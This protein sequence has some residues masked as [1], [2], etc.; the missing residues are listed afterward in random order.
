MEEKTDRGLKHVAHEHLL[1]LNENYIAKEGEIKSN[2]K[3]EEDETYSHLVHL[4]AADELSLD[5][6]LE[7]F[8]KDK[9]TLSDS[10]NDYSIPEFPREIEH[11][12]W[13]G[14]K[15]TAK[16]NS[17]PFKL[18]KC[19]GCRTICSGIFFYGK[20]MTPSD[21]RSISLHIGCVTL[22][23]IIKHEAH[24]HQLNQVS[25]KYECTACGFDLQQCKYRCEKCDFYIC[26]RCIRYARTYKHRWDPHPLELIYDAGMV[27]EHE[28]EYECE[29]CSKEI[30]TNRWFYH[31]SKCDL[32]IHPGCI[33]KLSYGSYKCV[34]FGATDINRDK[35]HPHKLTYV[36]NKKVRRCDKCGKQSFGQPV[37]QCAPCNTIF[38]SWCW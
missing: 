24:H 6:L 9:I 36:L 18:F 23:K 37:L 12:L 25:S 3:L 4:P 13:P 29:N 1:I 27:E 30:D 19:N 22:P 34:K 20:S 17:E 21:S 28:H 11:H 2:V 35:L 15:L 31:C 26:A 10:Y 32:S 16:K 38:C 5:L 7:Q 8:I 33:E 14:K